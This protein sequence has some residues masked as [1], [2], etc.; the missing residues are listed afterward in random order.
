MRHIY[1]VPSS[2]FACRCVCV[3][4]IQCI[5]ARSEGTQGNNRWGGLRGHSSVRTRGRVARPG[6][7][8]FGHDEGC[9][10][11]Q[12]PAAQYWN[13]MIVPPPHAIAALRRIAAEILRGLRHGRCTTTGLPFATP[14]QLQTC[15]RSRYDARILYGARELAR[16]A[17]PRRGAE[18][19]LGQVGSLYGPGKEASLTSTRIAP[20]TSG[21]GR[22]RLSGA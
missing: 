2:L 6:S 10:K 12:E 18:D 14:T 5:G 19:G 22:A 3:G 17:R 9:G 13:A 16:R 1:C 8:P 4:S 15:M 20:E 21:D 7:A 11:L